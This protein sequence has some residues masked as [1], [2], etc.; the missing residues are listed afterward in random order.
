MVRS[1]L[2][3]RKVIDAD[4]NVIDGTLNNQHIH[5]FP[6]P[7][8]T[9]EITIKAADRVSSEAIYAVYS[10]STSTECD[11]TTLI[12]RDKYT[13]NV[14][15]VIQVDA[16]AKLV[17]VMGNY[18]YTHTADVIT[19]EAKAAKMM[20]DAYSDNKVYFVG[21]YCNYLGL[22]Y[23]RKT[24]T[25]TVGAWN[26]AEWEQAE[27]ANDVKA[28]KNESNPIMSFPINL[29]RIGRVNGAGQFEDDLKYRICLYDIYHNAD[30][31][32]YEIAEGYSA[33]VYYYD[34][35]GNYL[36]HNDGATTFD[37]RTI[38]AGSYFRLVIWITGVT[39]TLQDWQIPVLASKVTFATAKA[40][41]D[42]DIQTGV[43]GAMDA[44]VAKMYQRGASPKTFSKAPCI[45]VAG[46]SNIDGRVPIADL[47]AEIVF[48]FENIKVG[49]DNGGFSAS[50]TAPAKWDITTSMF[51][52]L[53][54]LGMPIYKIKTAQGDTSISEYGA[55]NYH[56]TPFLE[57]ISNSNYALLLKFDKKI[58]KC[59]EV[60]PNTFDIRAFVWQQGEGDRGKLS[61]QAALDYY[62]N[63]KCLVAYVR[64]VVG[65]EKLPVICGTVS[66]NSGEYDPTVESATLRVAE[67]DP[68]MTCIDMS[69]A[70]LLDSYHFDATNAVY[71][72]QMAYDALIDFGVITGT[73]INPTRPW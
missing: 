35:E 67:E 40:K 64:G 42:E 68:Y 34:S 46:Q 14:D 71:F 11:S 73:K 25:G 63:F 2:L 49:N 38:I 48:P 31:I 69:G 53:N 54:A 61:K 16:T 70:T 50:E 13:S 21:D 28:I 62:K 58:K 65:D 37:A 27:I 59:I 17:L 18:V 20:A 7:T 55:S 45:I 19:N 32:T 5:V 15:K 6:I 44:L 10:A 24:Y 29:F 8:G 60:T 52:A 57:K 36:G 47:P 22:V 39:T 23:K 9:V 56:W 41:Q 3:S 72:G 66:H 4:G 12:E 30:I 1:E 33:Q 43:E 26:D 51:S